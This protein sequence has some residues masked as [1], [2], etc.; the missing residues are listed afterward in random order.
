MKAGRTSFNKGKQF[1]IIP[2]V[3]ITWGSYNCKFSI[4]FIW[5]RYQFCI[6]IFRKEFEEDDT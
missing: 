4:A 5:L 1:A 2:S 6:R 3:G